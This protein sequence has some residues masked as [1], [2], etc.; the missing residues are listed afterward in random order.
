MA[1]L[2]HAGNFWA[3]ADF[4]LKNYFRN[5]ISNS[6]DPD[7]DL[8]NNVGPDLCKGYQQTTKDVTGK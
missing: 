6:F 7:Q 2:L 1:K 8:T 3:N 4:F 5:T